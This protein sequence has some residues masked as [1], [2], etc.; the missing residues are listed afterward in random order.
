MFKLL[1]SILL[2]K[3]EV[4][5]SIKEVRKERVEVVILPSPI[6][7]WA[8]A[9]EKRIVIKKGK[10]CWRADIKDVSPKELTD[11]LEARLGSIVPKKMI[12]EYGE[13]IQVRKERSRVEKFLS[14]VLE[15]I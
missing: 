6:K 2:S 7:G 12:V 14:G 3:P 1:A 8:K 15:R 4:R 11:L 10:N 5:V 9:E 13:V